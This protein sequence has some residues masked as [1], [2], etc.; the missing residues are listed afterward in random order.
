M[1]VRKVTG[2]AGLHSAKQRIETAARSDCNNVPSWLYLLVCPFFGSNVEFKV[3][4]L[5]L[6]FAW[7]F[8]C[9]ANG[10]DLV[11]LQVKQPNGVV[12]Y[13]EPILTADKSRGEIHV[14]NPSVIEVQNRL[15]M[16]YRGGAKGYKGSCID[17]AF[18]DDGR[19]FTPYASNPV[20]VSDSPF[21]KK[22]CEDP[23]VVKF[24]ETYYMT[25]VG[26]VAGGNAL[27]QCLA[28]STDLIHWDKKGVVLTAIPDAWDKGMVKAAV[29]VPEKIAGKYIM[30]F[31]G[32]KSPWRTSLGMAVSDD[33][34]HWTQPLDH[35]IMT[36][37]PDHFDSVGVE[38]GATPIMLPEGIL[39]IYNGWNDARVHKTGWALFSR[40]HPS[41]MLKRC[42]DPFI[43]PLFDYEM[44]AR[45][46][47]TF[48]EGAVHFKG[49]WRFYYGASDDTIGLAEIDD[50]QTLLKPA[51]SAQPPGSPSTGPSPAGPTSQP[52]AP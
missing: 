2:V 20:V 12:R 33:L 17:L 44:K 48:T 43:E 28:T 37:R 18:S 21:D 35:S 40:D 45:K 7:C 38:P 16:L 3:P 9:I 34:L 30:Y 31:I 4:L 6:L 8:C 23:R 42:E 49:L 14:Y 32:Q 5:F 15:A 29:I 47:V 46:N 41:K 36:A 24:G 22:G 25:Y 50:I 19:T 51:A 13:S 39:L 11:K 1:V 52:S 10:Q 27:D 26:N